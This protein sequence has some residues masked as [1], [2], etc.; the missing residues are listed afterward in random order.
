MRG[1]EPSVKSSEEIQQSIKA[2][3]ER[4]LTNLEAHYRHIPYLKGLNS[5]QQI[6]ATRLEG[7]Y[8]VIA[9]PGTGKT[10]T[11]VY[12]VLHMIKS[13]TDPQ[14]IVV[15]TFTRKSGNELIY[16]INQLLPNTS[17]GFVG[18]F[19][20]FANHLSLM[21][22]RESP[23]SKFRLLDS[24]DDVQVHNH[25]LADTNHFEEPVRAGRLQKIISYCSNTGL[26]VADYIK[27]F[28]VK[29]LNGQA[30]AIEAYR[31]DYEKYKVDHLLTSY[32]DMIIKMS[33]YMESEADRIDLPYKFLMI[34]EYQD[35]NRMQLDFIKSIGIPN[36][37]AIGDDF[38][39]IYAF[40]G[41]D[42]RIILNFYNDFEKAAMIKLIE[43]YRSTPTIVDWV[44]LTVEASSQGYHKAL[45]SN[46]SI[47]GT[48]AMMAGGWSEDNITFILD[49]IQ[50]KKTSTHAIIYRYNK[51]RTVFEKAMID[52]E[53]DY[54]IYG[55]V[56]VLERK[57]IKDVLAFLMVHLNR[58]DIVSY[59]RILTIYP[60]IG[61]KTAR[62]LIK[63]DLLDTSGLNA[64]KSTFVEAVRKLVSSRTDKEV[65]LSAICEYYK[66]L[67]QVIG[68][69]YYTV[70]EVGED[71]TMLMELLK[72]YS[73]LENF[74][75]NLIL[76]PSWDYKKGTR[77]RV[78]LTTIH[79]AKGLEFDHVYYFHSHNWYNNYDRTRIEEDRRL[80]YVGISRAKE[81]LYV[82]DYTDTIRPFQAL[83]KDFEKIEMARPPE[84]NKLESDRGSSNVIYVDFGQK[85]G[86]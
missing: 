8:L 11:L 81:A 37:M 19:H 54:V 31:K 43:N 32:D 39:G 46:K 23:L 52:Q 63:S 42:H 51:Q 44:N 55:G 74:I 61:P 66:T 56:R 22:G 60:G 80:F 53:I 4:E 76:D 45:T 33:H 38:Q 85:K 48:V 82:M 47:P 2:L 57:H 67:Y 50:S 25:V 9:G 3:S 16:R 30:Q 36:T 13:G 58:R 41:A 49:Q 69:D 68:S 20:G 1:S 77:P 15:I 27:K 34:D 24:S 29:N 7:N 6:A 26:S 59:N 64:E 79:S 35:T 62:R 14:A 73:S 83:L 21:I 86:E 18:T 17:L 40:R 12:R 84:S 78:V 65:M 75:T 71:F 10:H 72:T 70:E 28:R 5:G